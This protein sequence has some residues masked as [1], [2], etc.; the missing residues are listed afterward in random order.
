MI[1]GFNTD[2]EYGGITYHVQT[3]DKGMETPLLL[4]L[5]YTGGEILASKR[6][7]YHDLIAD[8]FDEK[9]LQD[10][11]NKQHRLICAAIK[12]GRIDDLRK[13]NSNKDSASRTS[14]SK[15][16]DSAVKKE[17]SIKKEATPIIP[18]EIEDDSL[19][20]IPIE[21]LGVEI[22]EINSNEVPIFS[23]VREVITSE[24]TIIEPEKP[25][26]L[27]TPIIE[28][29]EKPTSISLDFSHKTPEKSLPPVFTPQIIEQNPP[30]NPGEPKT[31]ENPFSLSLSNISG[32]QDDIEEGIA[33][34]G[35]FEDGLKETLRISLIDEQEY[36]G[37][38][39]TTLKIRVSRNEKNSPA[40]AGANV[41]VKVLGAAFRP[42]I[43]HAKTDV[44]GLCLVHLQLPHFKTGRAAILIRA[45]TENAEAELRRI[46]TQG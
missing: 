33:D 20:E 13:M 21:L 18:V 43:F 38:D 26:I 25:K 32:K 42:L 10:R 39:R 30:L 40:I 1:T 27:I 3:E 4:S 28:E 34:F 19:L 29:V 14:E 35:V 45:T 9:I 44:F 16:K 24:I 11:L 7:P 8:G 46:V 41:M 5:V 17:P 22:L 36:Q 6:S 2:I 12:A 15:V 37:G 23:E 31:E